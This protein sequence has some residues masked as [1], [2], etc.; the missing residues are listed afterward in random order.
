MSEVTGQNWETCQRPLGGKTEIELNFN[1]FYDGLS[2][3]V[4][5]DEHPTKGLPMETSLQLVS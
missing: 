3:A 1:M 4:F 5:F 2:V